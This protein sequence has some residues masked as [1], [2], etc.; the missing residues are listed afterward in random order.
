MLDNAST[1][2]DALDPT[3]ILRELTETLQAP[4]SFEAA[5]GDV[6][7]LV[8]RRLPGADAVSITLIDGGP[9]TVASTDSFATELDERQY[10]DG[11]GPCLEAAEYQQTAVMPDSGEETRWPDFARSAV[12]LGVGSSLSAPLPSQQHISGALNIYA[13]K[14]HAFDEQSRRLAESLGAHVSLALVQ[15]FNYTDAARRADSLL[16]AMRSRAVIEQA[17]GILMAAR[18]LSASQAFDLLVATSQSEHRKLRD[19]AAG[20]VS[21]ASGHPASFDGS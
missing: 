5:M 16:E 8:R 6:A 17:K 9:G 10:R 4:A 1:R 14:P 12:A 15:S 13:K 11:W 3:G 2:P 7:D 18:E 21:R 19:V 20:L